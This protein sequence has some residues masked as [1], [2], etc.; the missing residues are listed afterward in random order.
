MSLAWYDLF[1]RDPS[2][3]FLLLLFWVTIISLSN[4]VLL[5]ISGLWK[6]TIIWSWSIISTPTS[7]LPLL[8]A[9]IILLPQSL[10]YRTAWRYSKQFR[11]RFSWILQCS[12]GDATRCCRSEYLCSGAVIFNS[13]FLT[14]GL[15]NLFVKCVALHS[16][17]QLFLYSECWR[18]RQM[19]QLR[20]CHLICCRDPIGL[21]FCLS[22]SAFEGIS[23]AFSCA[24]S[25]PCSPVHV[26]T[27]ASIRLPL[28][29]PLCIHC[30]HVFPTP[31]YCVILPY[32]AVK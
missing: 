15:S 30:A 17:L 5:K 20:L 4:I 28:C 25:A 14:P 26:G 29:S 19:L 6:Q 32:Y 11:D 24:L 21:G 22:S 23:G 1:F 7:F 13:S 3:A 12:G 27:A 9:D 10:L 18:M 16:L 2:L 31:I 8:K